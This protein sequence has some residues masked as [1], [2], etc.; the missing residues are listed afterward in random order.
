MIRTFMVV[1]V[2][3]D[4]EMDSAEVQANRITVDTVGYLRLYRGPELVGAYVP[5]SWRN[6]A[7]YDED[8]DTADGETAEPARVWRGVDWDRLAQELK[9]A[10][11][12]GRT[13]NI[14]RTGD[15]GRVTP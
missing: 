12:I 9:E 1:E 8:G 15:K 4:G 2:A 5:G 11:L 14:Y 13:F 6:V 3:P 10:G 7:P